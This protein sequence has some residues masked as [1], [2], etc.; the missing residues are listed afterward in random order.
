MRLLIIGCGSNERGDDVAGLLV[1]RRLRELGVPAIE[2]T[3]EGLSLIESWSGADRVVLVDAVRTGAATGVISRWDGRGAPIARDVFCV[4]THAFGV[5]EAVELART[6]GRL[7]PALTIYGIEAGGFERSAQPS[8][9]VLEAVDQLANQIA[10][11]AL[12]C[13]SPASSEN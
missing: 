8:L 4:S 3:G 1:A 13:M 10:Q 5:A 6:L 12:S 7:P 2:R 9:E 11:E